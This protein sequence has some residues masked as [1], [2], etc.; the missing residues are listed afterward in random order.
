MKPCFDTISVV[1]YAS[2]AFIAYTQKLIE[3][4]TSSN[5]NF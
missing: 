1:T 5:K 4:C 2:R 3:L